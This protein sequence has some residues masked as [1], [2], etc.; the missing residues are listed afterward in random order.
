MRPHFPKTE[1]KPYR[2]DCPFTFEFNSSARIIARE[3]QH[4]WLSIRY[5][6]INADIHLTYKALNNNLEIYLEQ[7]HKLAYD[8]HFKA[9]NILTEKVVN[10]EKDVYGLS[11]FLK[12]EV[13]SNTQFFLTDSS[14]HFLRASL[15]FNSKSNSDSLAPYIDYVNKDISRFIESFEWFD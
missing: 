2:T 3:D 1:F 5:P 11:Y 12:G 4:C 10:T 13:A 9:S 7:T 6:K 14:K 8:H 15:Y